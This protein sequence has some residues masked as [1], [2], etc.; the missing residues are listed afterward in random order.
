MDPIHQLNIIHSLSLFKRSKRKD[1]LKKGRN[2][3]NREY[4]CRLRTQKK[5]YLKRFRQKTKRTSMSTAESGS[6]STEDTFERSCS[7]IGSSIG[8]EEEEEDFPFH[9]LN[10]QRVTLHRSSSMIKGE[11]DVGGS[12]SFDAG[13]NS[14]VDKKDW[15]QDTKLDEFI[16]CHGWDDLSEAEDTEEDSWDNLPAAKSVYFHPDVVTEVRFRPVT[17]NEEKF[18]LFF[19]GMELQKYRDAEKEETCAARVLFCASSLELGD[20]DE[21][22]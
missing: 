19:G 14:D 2:N 18:H 13:N 3:S 17:T 21:E 7:S 9:Q 6:L 16:S 22:E 8:E 11:T 5:S 4:L 10:H 15:D 20:E 1:D 12:I